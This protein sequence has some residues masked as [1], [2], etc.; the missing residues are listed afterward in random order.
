MSGQSPKDLPDESRA[1]LAE[2]GFAKGDLYNAARPSYP[3]EALDYFAETFSLDREMHVLD[4][5][6]GT[7]IFT[8]QIRP[9]VG[10]VTAVEPS[11]SMRASLEASGVDAEVL[12][13]SDVEIPLAKGS[14][15]VAF[16]AQAFHWFDP[17]R[18][19]KELHRV[20]VPRGGLGLIWNER[21]ESVE[22]VAQ[23]SH[24]MMWDIKAPYQVGTDFSLQIA[25]GP[26]TDIERIHFSHSQTLSREGL[27][28]RVLT[29]SYISAMDEGARAGLMENVAAVVEQLPEPIVLPYVTEVYSAWADDSL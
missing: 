15:D 10:R 28:Q 4:L 13:G 7:G 12:D 16:V 29:T 6:A 25:D 19:L 2:R 8:R 3:H 24:A 9:Y 20:L 23:L 22:W 26:F 17:P 5:G 21:D 14:I 11:S 18:A 27:Y 1:R